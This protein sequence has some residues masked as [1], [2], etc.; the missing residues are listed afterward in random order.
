[1][2]N[3][4]SPGPLTPLEDDPDALVEEVE[5]FLRGD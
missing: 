5:R 1:M 3:D 4:T 2:M